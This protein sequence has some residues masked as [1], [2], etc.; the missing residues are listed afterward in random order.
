[1]KLPPPRAPREA[2]PPARGEPHDPTITAKASLVV[3]ASG[4]AG[5]CSAL[6]F[7]EGPRRRVCLIDAGLSPRRTS[8]LLG[9]MGLR[10]D[11]IDDVL[12]THLDRDH[13]HPGWLKRL[14]RHAPMWIHRRHVGRA[15]RER[16][17]ART[18][19]VFDD[20]EAFTTREGVTVRSSLE[21]HDSL[22]VAALRIETRAGAL[23]YATDLGRVTPSLV[24]LL[25]GVGTLAIESNYCPRMQAAADRPEFLKRRIMGGAGHLSNDESADAVSRIAPSG[26]VVL[27]HLSR[28]CNK[29]KIALDAHG[30]W[31]DRVVVSSQDTPTDPAPIAPARPVAPIVADEPQ[32]SLF[33]RAGGAAL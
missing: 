31:R 29:P 9:A 32:L 21:P 33:E 30:A 4:S 16:V 10:V 23:G 12:M 22:G 26:P 2:G 3:L 17:A 8:A 24:S 25:A 7:G 27:L 14:P 28:Q 6:I 15:E 20:G 13:C 11:Q 18:V 5:N 19:R 1:M